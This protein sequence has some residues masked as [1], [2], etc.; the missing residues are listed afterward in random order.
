MSH[1]HS[2]N[3]IFWDSRGEVG[4]T[5]AL[6]GQGVGVESGLPGGDGFL[7]D[8]LTVDHRHPLHLHRELHETLPVVHHH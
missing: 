5:R 3:P 1:Q 8:G 4:A 2:D 7:G 6:H